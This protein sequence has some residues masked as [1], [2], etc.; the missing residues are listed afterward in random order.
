M[1]PHR[2]MYTGR[3]PTADRLI[4]NRDVHQ[5]GNHHHHHHRNHHRR[6]HRCHHRRHHRLHH[7]R[8][9]HHHQISCYR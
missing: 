1:T 9:H 4:T 6:H 5:L 3:R 7:R 8:H 2:L